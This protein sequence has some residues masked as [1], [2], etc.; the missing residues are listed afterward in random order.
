M[1]SENLRQLIKSSDLKSIMALF[2]PRQVVG[3]LSFEDGVRLAVHFLFGTND[4]EYDDKF[5]QYSLACL[6]AARERYAKEWDASW[7]QDVLL[8]INYEL[9]YDYY[10][11]KYAAFKRALERAGPN[12]PP[13]LYLELA[14]CEGAPGTPPISED[15]AIEYLKLAL[16]D[17]PYYDAAFY[18]RSLLRGRGRVEEA[19]YWSQMLAGIDESDRTPQIYPDFIEEGYNDWDCLKA[20]L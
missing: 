6:L 17:R 10:D 16:K 11:E 3:Q 15:Q 13:G 7:K 12:P 2:E 5:R 4:P 9:V 19:D 18:L 14:R 20:S 8:G 1:V